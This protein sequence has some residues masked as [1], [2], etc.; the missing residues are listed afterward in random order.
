L[1][2]SPLMTEEELVRSM[3]RT[4]GMPRERA[5]VIVRS[6]PSARRAAPLTVP[7]SPAPAPAIE[8]PLRLTLPWSHL[9]SDNDKYTPALRDGRAVLVLTPEYREAKRQTRQLAER[10]LG[11]AAP[12]AFPLSIE[13]RVWVPDNMRAHDVCNFAKCCHDALEGV[14]YTKDRW[15][16]RTAWNRAGVDVDA[17]RA[18]ILIQPA[19]P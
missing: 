14:V 18:E 10:K 9:V 6:Q 16:Y 17:P 3:M 4:T 19:A 1:S 11:D 8:W 2:D 5:L 15:L 7:T 13:A 12:V